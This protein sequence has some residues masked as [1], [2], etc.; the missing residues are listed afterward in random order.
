M[1]RS[2]TAGRIMRMEFASERVTDSGYGCYVP[3][4]FIDA[5]VVSLLVLAT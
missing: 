2:L 5:D 3:Q 1:P 4:S